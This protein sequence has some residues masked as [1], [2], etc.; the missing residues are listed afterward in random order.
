MRTREPWKP[1]VLRRFGR[2]LATAFALLYGV[3]LVG[4]VFEESRAEGAALVAILVYTAIGIVTAWLNDRVGGGMLVVASVAL[5]SFGA[6]AAEGN[7]VTAAATLGGPFL[8]SGAALMLAS[9]LH[10]Q[11]RDE[12]EGYRQ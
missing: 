6:I 10:E 7:P 1:R 11:W 12:Q 8:L 2:L 9:T 3:L 5:A 4:D